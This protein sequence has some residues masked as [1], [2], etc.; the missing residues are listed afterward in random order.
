VT[1]IANM[2]NF[3]AFFSLQCNIQIIS[4]SIVIRHEV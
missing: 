1:I 2:K 3:L 4:T